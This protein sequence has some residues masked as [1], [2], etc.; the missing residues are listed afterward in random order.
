M[1][2]APTQITVRVIARAGKFL[3]DDIGGAEVTIRDARTGELLA[4]GRTHGGS[5]P[6]ALMT[7]PLTRNQ[8]IPVADPPNNNACRFDATLNLESPRLVEISVYGPLAAPQSANRVSA[9]TWV[10][11]GCDI[12]PVRN[13]RQDGFLLEIPGLMVQVLNPPAHYLPAKPDPSQ[14]IPIRANVTMMCGCPI[15]NASGSPWPE[16]DFEVTA[17]VRSQGT[18]HEIPLQYDPHA[19]GG[20]P[21]QFVS[22]QWVPGALGVYE[23]AVRAYQKSTGNTGVDFTTVNLQG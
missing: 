16:S 14:S 20:A 15:S 3:G 5:G 22:N 13:E 4:H 7:T 8:P 2:S 17:T 9:T 21:S 23:I 6:A 10:V 1:S 18:S 12:S 11:P 19:P